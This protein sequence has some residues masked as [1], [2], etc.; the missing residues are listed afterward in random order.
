MLLVFVQSVSALGIIRAAP[1]QAQLWFRVS[2]VYTCA[3]KAAAASLHAAACPCCLLPVLL[4]GA[5]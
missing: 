2:S 4:A 5:S 1:V 3:S